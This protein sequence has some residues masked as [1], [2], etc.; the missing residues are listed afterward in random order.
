M[1]G[2]ELW[3]VGAF[4]Q[5]SLYPNSESGDFSGAGVYSAVHV[6]FIEAGDQ[7]RL[8]IEFPGNPLIVLDKVE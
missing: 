5:M 2:D 1:R 6:R 4:A 7:L 8:E 3:V